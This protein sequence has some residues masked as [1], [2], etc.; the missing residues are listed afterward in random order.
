MAEYNRKTGEISMETIHELYMEKFRPTADITQRYYNGRKIALYGDSPY[1]RELLKEEYNINVDLL[2]TGVQKKVS[3]GMTLIDDLKGKN[4]TYYII[5][6]YLKSDVKIKQKLKALGYTEFKDFVFTKHKKIVLPTGF[7][8]YSDEYGNHIYCTGC[9]VVLDEDAGNV[10]IIVHDTANLKGDTLI[11]VNGFNSK[12]VINENCRIPS[13]LISLRS[14]ATLIIG[15]GTTFALNCRIDISY[16][17]SVFIGNDCMFSYDIKILAG[18]GH[19]IF[20]VHTG[21]Q[22]NSASK[23]QNHSIEI[24]DH[25]W[26]GVRSTILQCFIGRSSI[27]GACSLVKGKI[28]NNCIAAGIPAKVIKK[29]ITWSRENLCEDMMLC[30]EENIALTEDL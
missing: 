12:I 2:V 14:N 11:R 21:K 16:N 24:Q 20:D 6:P 9:Q 22:T 28:P 10:D 30:G 25:V 4:S 23:N 5:V 13:S 27:I 7:G 18:D 3:E 8:D 26:V 1:L 15:E 29:D 17:E 19:S